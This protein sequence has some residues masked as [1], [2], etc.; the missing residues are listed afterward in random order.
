MS[1][2]EGKPLA[3]VTTGGG[4][5]AG[6]DNSRGGSAAGGGD[7]PAGG[8]TPSGGDAKPDIPSE[9]EEPNLSD[10]RGKTA[11]IVLNE[12]A[13][14]QQEKYN[15]GNLAA[16][17]VLLNSIHSNI[18]VNLFYEN[19]EYML[20]MDIQ[21]DGPNSDPLWK[22]KVRFLRAQLTRSINRIAEFTSNEETQD[23]EEACALET[24]LKVARENYTA[25]FETLSAAP[26]FCENTQKLEEEFDKHMNWQETGTPQPTQV[27]TPNPTS[28][29]FYSEYQENSEQPENSQPP[30]DHQNPMWPVKNPEKKVPRY[31]GD[32]IKFNEFWKLFVYYVDS[33]QMDITEK[34]RILKNSLHGK[35]LSAVCHLEIGEE[36]YD[37][38]KDTI[39]ETFGHSNAAK[40]Q[41]SQRL[42]SLCNMK[43]LTKPSKFI[44][45]VS[46]LAQNL[47]Q[48]V[49]RGDTFES[50]STSFAPLVL[51]SIPYD[52]RVQ[53]DSLWDMRTSEETSRLES[54]LQFL[55]R[56]KRIYE[57]SDCQ[58]TFL[59]RGRDSQD[60]QPRSRNDRP[61]SKEDSN[62]NF[63]YKHKT[64]FSFGGTTNQ[65]DHSCV[66]CGKDHESSKCSVKMSPEDRK[67]R[68]TDQKACLRCLRRNH[69]AKTCRARVDNCSKCGGRHSSLICGGS[70]AG[71][72][73]TQS[74][75]SSGGSNFQVTA[76][77]CL[78]QNSSS[79]QLLRTAY[80]Y[81][82]NGS[83]RIICRVLLD[84][85]AMRSL[86]SDRVVKELG[87]ETTGSEIINIHG[88]AGT[89]TEV[90]NMRTCKIKLQSRF[91]E[92]CVKIECLSIPQVIKGAI[93]YAAAFKGFHPAADQR[94]SGF[95]DE[96]DILIAN[97]WLHLIYVGQERVTI[98]RI[99]SMFA[100]PTIFGWVCYGSDGSNKIHHSVFTSSAVIQ[101][102]VAASAIVGNP[103]VKK[104]TTPTDLE[105]LWDTELL[106]IENPLPSDE[107]KSQEE[108]IKFFKSSVECMENGR[109]SV[110][111]PFRDN[112]KTL[113]DNQKISYSRLLA[114][115]KNAKK[116]PSLLKAVDAEI[117]KYIDLGFAELASPRAPGEPA[118]FLPLLAVA[119]KS[120][121]NTQVRKVR[122]VKDCG[123]RS[124]D[125]ASLNDVLET[126]PNL[127]PDILAVLMNFR[128]HSIVIV[129]DVQQ[130]FM[131]TLTNKDHRKFLTFFW[132]T[133][134]SENP[135]APIKEYWQTVLDF[136]LSCSPFLLC[137]VLRHHLD[138]NIE[139][140]PGSANILR[141]IRDTFFMD[142]FCTG[143]S[144]VR[145]AKN[146]VKLVV[147]TFTF[148]RKVTSLSTSG[149]LTPENSQSSFRN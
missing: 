56:K 140:T 58:G 91:S 126:G 59:N 137:Q 132:P 131:Q 92:S 37:L 39:S 128:K 19:L 28:E 54:L 22:N 136:G 24:D 26:E 46:L 122:I 9:S 62:R 84:P 98:T 89:V 67:K 101:N 127:P 146:A 16:K 141:D 85:G 118:H 81:A 72:S 88:I 31:N 116:D 8:V 47:R 77:G 106:G 114:F 35:A 102:V 113:G 110:S 105:H 45:F 139:K 135:N 96:I 63:G 112:I 125:E 104:K 74:G 83:K 15:R 90:K 68:C 86:I 23:L 148:L 55:I 14:K 32:P 36:S 100:C 13:K 5:M 41:L 64:Q 144:S 53:F 129:A 108:L 123:C 149:R 52:L 11:T 145:D 61:D 120:L 97:D 87:I 99:G 43:D 121:S 27:E 138:L 2:T 95:P 48:L 3:L 133:G 40:E 33:R 69:R 93:P 76:A 51:C 75:G 18:V 17:Y 143:G 142:D 42:H 115:L 25:A 78:P 30:P 4:L 21:P 71:P 82:V 6:G 79:A 124:K 94:E 20:R 38:M 119:K 134:V 73:G 12:D 44:H 70:A 107:E 111:L 117:Q 65:V 49:A 130:A 80:V 34:S 29:T 50:L 1:D 7:T 60:P 66:F 57:E 103:T 147:F 109:Y 10:I